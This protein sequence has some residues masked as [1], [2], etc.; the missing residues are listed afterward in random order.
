MPQFNRYVL[1]SDNDIWFKSPD[2]GPASRK[3]AAGV[4][5]PGI[6]PGGGMFLTPQKI[7]TDEII[8]MDGDT[9]SL[10]MEDV[11]TFFM[12]RTRERYKR[13]GMVYKRGIL[14]HGK[15]GTGKSVAIYRVISEAI[16]NDMIV[17]LD[18]NPGLV[19]MFISS[20]RQLENDPAR[21]V[22]VI[23]E[24][25]DSILK[26][27][28]TTILGLLDGE[29]VIEN[30]IY[31]GTTNYLY[32][33]A[34][35]I[36]NRPSRFSCVVEAGAPPENVRRAYYEKKFQ[37][38]TAEDDPQDLDLW[39]AATA[40][41]VIDNLKDLFISV[42]VF[43]T[44]FLKAVNK[45]RKM[46]YLAELKSIEELMDAVS[47]DNNQKPKDQ[48]ISGGL[49]SEIRAEIEV[50]RGHIDKIAE[51]CGVE[52]EDDGASDSDDD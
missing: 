46:S 19:S 31:L 30:V 8:P 45:L 47:K 5:T 40:G 51:D 25:L 21:R 20:I 6:M 26:Q 18:P 13:H 44:D 34:D 27:H 48:K 10:I 42:V 49:M 38:L 12:E 4:Y 52:L 28:E 43:G 2:A 3:L 41:M 50:L 37:M 23:W 24:E 17:L 9:A 33:I 29:H 14:L 11:E 22:L 15:P 39:V 1:D 7:R 35:R 32:N 16:K 36:T